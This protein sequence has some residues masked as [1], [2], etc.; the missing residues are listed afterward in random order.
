MDVPPA[1]GRCSVCVDGSSS[2]A[3]R[4]SASLSFPDSQCLCHQGEEYHPSGSSEPIDFTVTGSQR[5]PE[6]HSLGARF[7]PRSFISLFS[8][9]LAP[10]L[11]KAE[12]LTSRRHQQPFTGVEDIPWAASHKS[13]EVILEVHPRFAYLFKEGEQSTAAC[14]L[15]KPS[16]LV[17][18]QQH[19]P[20][21]QPGVGG[22]ASSCPQSTAD[23]GWTCSGRWKRNARLAPASIALDGQEADALE[24]QSPFRSFCLNLPSNCSRSI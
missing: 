9:S 10:S 24:V 3:E 4:S 16:L 15:G 5:L 17:N 14:A 22:H 11:H 20:S 7:H 21:T 18:L 12:R 1:K 23:P 8:V 13:P 6:S 2:S 19:P